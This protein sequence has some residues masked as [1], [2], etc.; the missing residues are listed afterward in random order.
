[1]I[2][3][4]QVIP[5]T[6]PLTT[7]IHLGS[8]CFDSSAARTQM[9]VFLYYDS[10]SRASVMFSRL[11]GFPWACQPRDQL[12]SAQGE[13]S[14]QGTRLDDLLVFWRGRTQEITSE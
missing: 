4:G 11:C 2:T 5:L 8:V 12:P 7:L 6:D 10:I 14:Q 1:M 9:N 3:N 13:P